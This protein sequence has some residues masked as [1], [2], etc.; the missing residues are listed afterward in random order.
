MGA[1]SVEIIGA[2]GNHCIKATALGALRNGLSAT[3]NLLPDAAVRRLSHIG[4]TTVP[5]VCSPR[6]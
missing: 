5:G 4:S 2:G 3:V 1:D 6:S